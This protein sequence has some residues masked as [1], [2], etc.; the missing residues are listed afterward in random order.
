M[1]CLIQ[2]IDVVLLLS[3]SSFKTRLLPLVEAPEAPARGLLDGGP[4]LAASL[5]LA[6]ADVNA[7]A[8]KILML[9]VL[10]L[11]SPPIQTQRF[12]ITRASYEARTW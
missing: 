11:P 3:Q 6:A 12:F 9:L 7:T 2:G 5:L 1:A 4:I 8:H 10:P